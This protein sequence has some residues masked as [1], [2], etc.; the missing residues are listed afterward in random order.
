M[1]KLKKRA[2]GRY[3]M[4]V[5]L[6][7]GEDGKKKQ[8]TVYGRTQKEALQKAAELKARLG[9][10]I[11]ITAERD[12]FK[13][14]RDRWIENKRMSVAATTLC[15][16]RTCTEPMNESF[17]D[18]ELPKVL[19][20]QIQAV[21]NDMYK[22]GY[23]KSTIQKALQYTAQIFKLA[24]INR[25]TD[26]DPT[27]AVEIPQHAPVQ[28]RTAITEEQQRWIRETPHRAQVAAMIM[29]CYCPGRG[30]QGS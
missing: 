20:A 6:G 1:P 9:R 30:T 24:I 12:T 5:Y 3:Q 29:L 19:P 25:I 22:N 27:M 2:D 16:Y 28:H 8:K 4:Q 21:I 13:E 7:V 23:S 18:M 26:Y 10:G 14:W 17:G 15:S 11:D